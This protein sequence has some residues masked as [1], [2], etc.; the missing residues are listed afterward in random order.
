MRK[1][2]CRRTFRRASIE[3][4]YTNESYINIPAAPYWFVKG[5]AVLVA[6]CP[7]RLHIAIAVAHSYM[8]IQF[9]LGCTGRRRL[10]THSRMVRTALGILNYGTTRLRHLN[11]NNANYAS[12][13]CQPARELLFCVTRRNGCPRALGPPHICSRHYAPLLMP[14][15]VIWWWFGSLRSSSA[16]RICSGHWKCA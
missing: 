15:N 6:V 3:S 5:G 4:V 13:N 10:I 16:N 12:A 2:S 14:N 1:P 8:C 11:I 9:R 7:C